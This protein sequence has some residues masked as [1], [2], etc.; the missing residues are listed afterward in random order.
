M[1]RVLLYIMI[2]TL[3]VLSSC[4][5]R[6]KRLNHKNMIPEKELI[7][8]LTDTYIADGILGLPS[9]RYWYTTADSLL[10][11]NK[12]IE[13]H[14]YTK[15]AMDRTMKYYFIKK[16]K[17][18]VEIYDRVLGNLSEME[19][20]V[21]KEMQLHI[22]QTSEFWKGKTTYILPDPSGDDSTSFD[23]KIAGSGFYT[24]RFT[25]IIF[26]SDELEKPRLFG[27]TC[28]LDSIETGKRD[29]LNTIEYIKDGQPHEYHMRVNVPYNRPL[30]LKG[31]FINS[32]SYSES[33]EK[34]AIIKAISLTFS[35]APV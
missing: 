18:L 26:P 21:E 5:G 35:T 29:Y 32:H 15:E 33:L 17:E 20:L 12:V 9:I 1:T 7:K 19:S 4:S 3:L 28:H 13:Q 6:K 34:H 2:C 8:I 30:Y 22:A 23:I 25:A 14:G 10:T 27:Y 24:L 31:W 16:P 11:Y